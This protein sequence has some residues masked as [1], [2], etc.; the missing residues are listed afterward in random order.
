MK[1]TITK[2]QI[3]ERNFDSWIKHTFSTKYWGNGITKIELEADSEEFGFC[4]TIYVPNDGEDFL[5][6]HL[7]FEDDNESAKKWRSE[8]GKNSMQRAIIFIANHEAEISSKDEFEYDDKIVQVR[9]ILD[10]HEV[11][12]PPYWFGDQYETYQFV[13]DLIKGMSKINDMYKLATQERL[14]GNTSNSLRDLN[15]TGL[16]VDMLNDLSK[17]YE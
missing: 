17:V 1:V 11:F 15:V 3:E 16:T 2:T 8:H 12:T 7:K 5:F 10:K 14:H 4:E 6:E 13:L 9:E